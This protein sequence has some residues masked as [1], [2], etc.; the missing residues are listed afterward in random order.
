MKRLYR[1][2]RK[3]LVQSSLNMVQFGALALTNGSS[4]PFVQREVSYRIYTGIHRRPPVGMNVM[5]L[6]N[7]SKQ[8]F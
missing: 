5:E 1:V 2:L 6:R 8:L 7:K 3:L 4:R